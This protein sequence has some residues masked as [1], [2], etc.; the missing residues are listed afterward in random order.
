MTKKFISLLISAIMVLSLCT[1]A[2]YAG[3]DGDYTYTVSNGVAT[4]KKY[5]GP[6]GDVAIP[7]TLGGYPV[8]GLDD[9]AFRGCCDL[10]SVTIPDS[11]TNIG[12]YTFD[13]CTGLTSVILGSGVT[14]IGEGTFR[15]C[16]SLT[17]VTI[18]NSVTSIDYWAF[19]GCRNLTSV[20]IPDS[21]TSIGREAFLDCTN[22]TSVTIPDS[23]TNI[24]DRAFSGTALYDDPSNWESGVLYLGRHLIKANET[25][26]GK[27]SVK[28][29]TLTIAGR[30]FN[31]C[32]GLTSVTIPDSVTSIGYGA[33]SCCDGLTSVTIPDSV[34]SIGNSAFFD[35]ESL[36]EVFYAGTR[37]QFNAIDIGSDNDPLL[38]AAI[39]YGDDIID[40]ANPTATQSSENTG[41]SVPTETEAPTSKAPT[42]GSATV[43]PATSE[44]SEDAPNVGLIIGIAAA[45]VIAV[46][47]AVFIII[48]KKKRS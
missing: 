35:C 41:T 5:N 13:G 12:R 11:V 44:P 33:F 36:S 16:S 6:G 20:T 37:E 2:A 22:L 25:T 1:F 8:K 39:Y 15:D 27:Y 14:S 10:T 30:A 29:G 43:A 28:P 7:A 21:V 4:V 26:Q 31:Y 46:A 40:T 32:T 47:A 48:I 42:S 24:G 3:T 45:V 34:T 18:G 19:Y 17:S 38:N 23:V 9:F